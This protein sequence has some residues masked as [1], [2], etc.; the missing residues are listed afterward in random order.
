MKNKDLIK[1]GKRAFIIK[2]NEATRSTL[3]HRYQ[4]YFQN[5]DNMISPLLPREKKFKYQVEHFGPNFPRF[6][7]CLKGENSENVKK[8]AQ[9]FLDINPKLPIH[10]L[11]GY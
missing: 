8:I 4:V 9:S 11:N 6:H 7:F 2:I 1:T 10:F 5:Y 3:T